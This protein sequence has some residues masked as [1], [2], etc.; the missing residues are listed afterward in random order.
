MFFTTFCIIF[1][2]SV[3]QANANDIRKPVWAGSFY[4][5]SKSELKKS[6]FQ[7]TLRAQQ[8]RVQIP[9]GK[10][11]KTLILPHAGYI[12][13]GLTA[14]HASLVLKEKQFS[15]V[16]L[17]GPDHRVGF[18]NGSISDFKAFQTPL[19]LVELHKNNETLR[20]RQDMFRNIPTSDM[21]EHSLE[22]ILP[23]L[24]SYLKKFKII[25]IV[26]GP[27]HIAG[28]TDAIDPI[29]DKNTLVVASSDL[30][31][32]LSYPGAVAK[33]KETINMI[34]NLETGKLSRCDSC[35]CGKIP[36]L[37]VM[38]MARRH[39]WQPVLLHYSNSGDTAGGKSKVVGYTTIAFYGDLS[40]EKKNESNQ[41]FNQKQGQTL[42]KLARKTLKE[43]FGQK[44]G[45]HES[46]SL[47][48]ALK[49]S[50]F[51]K[52]CGTFVT[53]KINNQLRGCIGNLTANESALEGVKRNSINAAFHD[54]RFSPLTA[55]ELG[56]VDIEVSILTEPELLEYRD[57]SDLLSKLR[58]NVDGVI[59]RKGSASATFLP[60]VWEQLPKPEEFL[61]HLCMKAGLPG[62]TWKKSA[63]EVMTYQVQYFDEEK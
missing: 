58:V 34:L 62:N 25:P 11:L 27:S 20:L 15:K 56:Q 24:Q 38:E 26:L 52:L 36:I 44:R 60:Q 32:Y 18:R 19:G 55:E 50:S 1:F 13:S 59:I 16:I 48:S 57:G 21:M 49:D 5:A 29:L 31:H 41:Y 45:E 8:T 9:S 63:L 2:N 61:T 30:S 3:E 23:F 37:I 35:A 40:M 47:S 17:L 33:D 43:R 42:V 54:P 46:D 10:V 14:A 6:I 12:Y 28:I 22:V 51:N 53:L 39:G 7:L 4:P